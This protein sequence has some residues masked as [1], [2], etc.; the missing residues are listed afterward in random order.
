MLPLLRSFHGENAMAKFVEWKE[1]GGDKVKINLDNVLYIKKSN[2]EIT[3][4]FSGGDFIVI[5]AQF[6][7][8]NTLPS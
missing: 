7:G 6:A 8:L 1:V 4:H 3:V 5:D 2:S